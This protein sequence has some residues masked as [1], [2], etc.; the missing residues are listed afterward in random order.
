MARDFENTPVYWKCLGKKYF[1]WTLLLFYWYLLNQLFVKKKLRK[2][3]FLAWKAVACIQ[4]LPI[5]KNCLRIATAKLII[6]NRRPHQLVSFSTKHSPWIKIF[7]KTTLQSFSLSIDE[8]LVDA[9]RNRA[10]TLWMQEKPKTRRSRKQEE[11]G[12]KIR[13]CLH[14]V[15]FSILLSTHLVPC[16]YHVDQHILRLF[17]PLSGE[18]DK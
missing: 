13:I 10:T 8:R 9:S 16:S 6:I 5:K 17:E 2:H 7:H 18:G 15:L 14:F 3:K 12:A 11:A 1:S 4:Y